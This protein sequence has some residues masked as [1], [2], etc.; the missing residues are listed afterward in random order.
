LEVGIV[1]EGRSHPHPCHCE[2][3]ER[4]AAAIHCKNY[5]LLFLL[6]RIQWIAAAK[7][8]AALQQ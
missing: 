2:A 7:R 6:V 1:N 4:L 8:S 5:V 3:A